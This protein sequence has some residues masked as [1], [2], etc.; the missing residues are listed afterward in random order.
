MCAR[1]SCTRGP[2][3]SG[4]VSAGRALIRRRMTASAASTAAAG[5]TVF[6][7]VLPSFG[8]E[9]SARI[10]A[11]MRLCEK[12]HRESFRLGVYRRGGMV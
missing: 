11:Q 9:M 10:V 3:R 2:M 4:K 5:T 7:M 6:H 8:S 1:R 12:V